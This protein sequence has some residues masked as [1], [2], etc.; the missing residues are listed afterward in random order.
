MK[1]Y[2]RKTSKIYYD[3]VGRKTNENL[4]GKS[5]NYTKVLQTDGNGRKFNPNIVET[6]RIDY[7]E[8]EKIKESELPKGLLSSLDSFRDWL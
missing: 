2:K 4:Y 6:K 8:W 5:G 3:V 7:S 1:I